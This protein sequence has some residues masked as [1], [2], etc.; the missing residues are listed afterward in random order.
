MLEV[1]LL[2]LL[3]HLQVHLPQLLLLLLPLDQL[4]VLQPLVNQLLST[5][6]YEVYHTQTGAWSPTQSY[7]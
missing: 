7:T 4:E 5:E 2:L 1:R 6:H 3:H